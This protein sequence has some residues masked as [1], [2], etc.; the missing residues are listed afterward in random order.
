MVRAPPGRK[1]ARGLL[2]GLRVSIA[3]MHKTSGER[4]KSVPAVQRDPLREAVKIWRIEKFDAVETPADSYGQFFSGDSYIVE[5]VYRADNGKIEEALLYF[6]QGEDSTADEKGSSAILCAKF[7]SERFGGQATQVR[8]VQGKEPSNFLRLFQ[9]K[10]VL[11]QGGCDSGFRS[12]RADSTTSSTTADADA[13]PKLYHI[14]G[15]SLSECK[16]TQVACEAQNLNSNDVLVLFPS[17]SEPAFVWQGA[18]ASK[19]ELE[20]GS[21]LAKTLATTSDVGSAAKVI[22]EKSEPDEF[23]GYFKTG[24]QEYASD[25]VLADPDFAP[26][27]FQVSNASGALRVEEAFQFTQEDLIEEDVMLLDCYSAVYVWVGDGAHEQEKNEAPKIAEQY[28]ESS[29]DRRLVEDTPIVIVKAGNEPLLFTCHFVGWDASKRKGFADLYEEK[30]K[31]RN[32][33]LQAEKE[34]DEKALADED[35]KRA[36]KALEMEQKR[37]SEKR[38]K[39]QEAEEKKKAEEG[40]AFGRKSVIKGEAGADSAKLNEDG[41]KTTKSK[42]SNPQ[43]ANRSTRDSTK[44]NDEKERST[45]TGGVAPSPGSPSSLRR[46]SVKGA[47]GRWSTVET[48]GYIG[49]AS[50]GV[51]RKSQLEAE[52]ALNKSVGSSAGGGKGTKEEPTYACP[53]STKYSLVELSDGKRPEDVDPTKK[54]HYLAADEFHTVFAMHVDEW[55]KLPVWKRTQKKKDK[56]LF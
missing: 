48:G 34:A 2:A 29:P 23:W 54:E 42:E 30:Q 52:E 5:Y 10:M 22:T 17:E 19:D 33:V 1:M 3:N 20:L 6:W 49:F 44:E 31:K 40:T 46:P 14:R 11:H 25:P 12:T 16:A 41:V 47:N 28:I 39:Q 50:T 56:G 7:D 35:A 36:S 37:E 15:F 32:S 21:H 38:Q 27:L 8:V 13:Y 43:D 18:G 26:R 55:D 9:G 24:K 51:V 45:V 4:R 53:R